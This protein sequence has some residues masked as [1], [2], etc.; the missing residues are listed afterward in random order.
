[1]GEGILGDEH[2]QLCNKT[3]EIE[4]PV[5]AVVAK[6]GFYLVTLHHGDGD[7]TLGLAQVDAVP[8]VSRPPVAH[9]NNSPQY[10]MLLP[11]R[12]L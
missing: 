1:V 3:A 2:V 10:A 9:G 8:A 4:V 11:A 12:I 7:Q 6:E 5:D